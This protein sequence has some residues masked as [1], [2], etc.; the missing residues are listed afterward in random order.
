[1]VI[2]GNNRLTDRMVKVA[3]FHGGGKCGPV[4]S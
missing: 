2:N 4:M 3:Y 1:M